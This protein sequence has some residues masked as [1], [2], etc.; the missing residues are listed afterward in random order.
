M[1][2]FALAVVFLFPLLAFSQAA[3]QAQPPLSRWFE[4]IQVKGYAHFRYNRLLETNRRIN[5]PLCDGSIGDKQGFFMRRA[6]LTFF[7]DVSD[8]VY[9]YIQPDYATSSTATFNGTSATQQNYFQIRDAYFDYALSEDKEWR[10]RSGISK[11]PYGF[12]NLQS[13]SLRAAFDRSDAINSATPNER[14]T[15][16]FL[17]FAPTEIRERFKKLSA[18]GLKGSGDYGVVAL[19]AYN[20]QS[21]NRPEKN[22]DLHRVIRVTY[23]WVTAGGQ[24]LET[25]LQAY[26][27]KYNNTDTASTN[28]TK[29]DFYDG[30]QAASFILYPQP[31]GFQAEYN[32]GTGP[33]FEASRNAVVGKRLH[34]GYAQVNYA[35]E[36]GAHRYFP[37]VRFQD[38]V[39]GKKLMT[40]QQ[41]N[42]VNE[43]ELGTEWQPDPAFELTV[44]YTISDRTTQSDSTNRLHLKGNFLRLQAQF[45]Y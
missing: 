32:V 26:E 6:R 14:D 45:N 22:N 44:A 17:M 24:F 35:L 13:S 16:V 8:R 15:G 27:G 28:V 41:Y 36:H 42:R 10:V 37:Y 4:K 30:R 23:P 40:N 1:R 18:L 25:S 19:G 39:G 12:D 5:C 9:I 11:V 31:L 2:L 34:G 33:Q 43:W 3:T 20:G 7:G 38:Y 29:G 21:L